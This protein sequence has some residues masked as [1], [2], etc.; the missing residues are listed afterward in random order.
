MS[1]SALH[2]VAK[3]FGVSISVRVH[4]SDIV[5]VT[6]VR[7]HAAVMMVLVGV[8]AVMILCWTLTPA[9]ATVAG[10]RVEY[11]VVE[12]KTVNVWVEV[13]KSLV[14]AVGIA[15]VAANVTVGVMGCTRDRNANEVLRVSG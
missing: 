3:A 13:R 9:L 6:T 5:L 15:E 14:M 8:G 4:C 1:T 12:V 2:V 10:G 7:D 11:M